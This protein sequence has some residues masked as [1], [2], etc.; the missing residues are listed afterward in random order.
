[1]IVWTKNPKQLQRF[2]AGRDRVFI[3]RPLEEALGP[4]NGFFRI[5]EGSHRMGKDGVT[6][7]NAKDIRLE[8]GQAIILD[9]DLQIEYPQAGGGVGLAKCIGKMESEVVG[10]EGSA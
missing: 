2:R 10:S 9:G 1:M 6:N 3:Y 5:V 4:E 8:P 7:A